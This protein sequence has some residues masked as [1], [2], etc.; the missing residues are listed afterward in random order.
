M[1]SKEIKKIT[2]NRYALEY[3]PDKHENQRGLFGSLFSSIYFFAKPIFNI[4]RWGG[5]FVCGALILGIVFGILWIGGKYNE[6]G[7]IKE[8]ITT[9]PQSSVV[10]DRNGEEMF[11]FF[12]DKEKREIVTLEQ[13][14]EVMQLAVIAME[15]ENFYYNE[16]G[17]PWTNLLAAAVK[18]LK[19]GSTAQYGADRCRGGSGLSQQLIKKTIT[20]RTQATLDNKIDELLGAYKFNQEVSKQDVLRIYLNV[21]PFGRNTAGIQA[22]SMTY[23]GHKIDEKDKEGT[24]KLSVPEACFLGSLLPKPE[25]FAVAIRDHIADDKAKNE[26]WDELVGRKNSCIDK[27]GNKEIR[28][29]NKGTIINTIEA[30]KYKTQKADFQPYKG[31]EVKFGHIKNFLM[32]ELVNKYKENKD[33]NPYDFKDEG[34]VLSKGLKIKTT[35]DTK[36]QKELEDITAKIMKEQ[37]IPNGGN[38]A[39]SVVLDGPTGEILAM[40]G[41]ADFNNKGIQG[42]VNIVTSPRQPGSSIKP[43]V[44]ASAFEKGFNPAT[45]LLDTSIDF[46]SF[47]PLNF[48]KK[49]YGA[50]SMRNALQNSLNIPAVKALYLSADPSNFPNGESGL[51]NFRKFA[52]KVG[53][54]FPYWIDGT[55]GVAT[56]LGGCEVKMIDHATGI[57]TILQEGKKIPATPFKEIVSTDTGSFAKNGEPTKTI[58]LYYTAN[59]NEDGP[60]KTVEKA[61]D[62]ATARQVANVMTDSVARYQS[63]WG[64]TASYLTL[65]DWSSVNGIASKTGTTNDVKDMWVVGGSPYYTVLVWA[66]NTDGTPMNKEASS[67]GVTG[68]YWK[69]IMTLLHK[70]KLKKGFSKEGLTD[71]ALSANTGL[72]QEGGKKELLTDLQIKLLKEAKERLLKPEYRFSE[73][74]IFNNRTIAVSK[75]VRVNKLDNLLIPDTDAGKA[76]P[77]DLISSIT[78]AGINSEF[79]KASNWSGG[80]SKNC[81]NEFSELKKEAAK[82]DINVNVATGQQASDKIVAFVKNPGSGI[83]T[84]FIEI[85]IGGQYYGSL[86]DSES[87]QQEL[88]GVNGIKDVEITVRNDA[89]L[90]QKFLIPAVIFGTELAPPQ[91][92]SNPNIVTINPPQL[93]SQISSNP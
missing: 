5:V 67:S 55:C 70:D 32:Y 12:D 48:D 36:L 90:E 2:Q 16:D 68:P 73:N 25:A 63:I 86:A 65:N 57:N 88:A 72:L 9:P 93:N 92:S 82:I 37:I 80:G 1:A 18:C 4:F 83:K 89:G 58:D 42:E 35:F 23:F 74:S 85:K 56:A 77:A 8:K 15:D 46:G 6:L 33:K 69:E 59:K 38:N 17:I 11:K 54:K 61:M 10:Y 91:P 52:E 44:Y 81:P 76:W 26:T 19:P 47:K 75:T 45:I 84:K 40:V 79:P 28:G 60:Y 43:Y 64:N 53:V 49:F 21:V 66:G 39:A 7:S 31:E 3:K 41:S 62:P 14:P 50:I 30:E 27:L 78:C 20:Q 29:Q 24:Y 87:I 13:I 51:Y 71:T 34:D 22:A